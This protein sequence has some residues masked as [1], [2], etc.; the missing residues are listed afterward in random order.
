MGVPSSRHSP[1]TGSASAATGPRGSSTTGGSGR[2]VSCATGFSGTGSSCCVGS[3]S[4][5]Y[6]FGLT[7]RYSHSMPCAVA[8]RSERSRSAPSVRLPSR[9][10]SPRVE[11]AAKVAAGKRTINRLKKSAFT[12]SVRSARRSQ[13]ESQRVPVSCLAARRRAAHSSQ[14]T[15]RTGKSSRPAVQASQ[16]GPFR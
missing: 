12:K 9:N 16:T 6:G 4:R 15:G 2:R 1:L 14:A 5:W 7:R 10:Q 11:S 8:K 3:I 13:T